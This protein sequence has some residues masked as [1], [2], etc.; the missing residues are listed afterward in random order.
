MLQVIEK[1]HQNECR[2]RT[3]HTYHRCVHADVDAVD[4]EKFLIEFNPAESMCV[5]C[6]G[7]QLSTQVLTPNHEVAIY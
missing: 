5:L 7:E 6:L 1:E 4:S 3:A 2:H